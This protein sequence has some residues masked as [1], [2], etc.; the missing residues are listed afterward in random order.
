M[1]ARTRSGQP[2]RSI[3]VATLA[4]LAL[5]GGIAV[6]IYH[7]QYGSIQWW[8]PPAWIT[9]CDRRYQPAGG[10]IDKAA[11]Q[12]RRGHLPGDSPY[13]VTTVDR[14]PPVVGR[15]LLASVTPQAER[16]RL[17]LPCAM[18]VFLQWS[19]HLYLPYVISGG[20]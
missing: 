16:A 14:V 3:V 20:P 19:P 6:V 17:H 10:P 9:W 18:E 2:A 7:N 1:P 5:S 8:R 13:P 15:P 4:V 12:L 11:V